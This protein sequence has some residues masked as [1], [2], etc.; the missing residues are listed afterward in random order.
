MGDDVFMDFEAYK[1]SKNNY[2]MFIIDEHKRIWL[3][4]FNCLNTLLNYYI[5]CH[6]LSND[7]IMFKGVPLHLDEEMSEWKIRL[8]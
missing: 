8:V 2:Q 4:S 6:N 3:A 7:S 5:F 1:I